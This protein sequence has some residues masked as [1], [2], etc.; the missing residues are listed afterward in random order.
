MIS[1]RSRWTLI[2]AGL[3][4]VVWVVGVSAVETQPWFGLLCRIGS[5]V[6]GLLVFMFL[7]NLDSLRD[8]W[9][10]DRIRMKR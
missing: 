8:G 3:W 7:W 10:V 1:G 4:L 5:G 9:R 2:A 6:I